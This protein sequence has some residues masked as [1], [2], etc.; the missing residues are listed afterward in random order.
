MV[1]H[2]LGL[3]PAYKVTPIGQERRYTNE[4]FAWYYSKQIVT[5]TLAI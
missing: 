4:I 3:K 5:Y 2:N 1:A